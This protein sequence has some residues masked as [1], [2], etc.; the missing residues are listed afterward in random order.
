MCL[1]L[2]H[3]EVDFYAIVSDSGEEKSFRG[4][5][6]ALQPCG[7]AFGRWDVPP[8]NI[9]GPAPKVEIV[10]MYDIL[11]EFFRGDNVTRESTSY[12]LDTYGKFAYQSIKKLASAMHFEYDHALWLDSEAIAVRPFRLRQTFDTHIKAPAVF[13]SRMRNTDF[14]GEIMN[15][16]A[17]VL[18]RSIDSFGPLLWTLESVQWIIERDVLRDMVRYVE[19]AHGRDFWSVWTE[20]HGPFEI[21]LYNLHIVARKLETVSS[22]FSKYAVLETEREMIRFG[23]APAFPEMEFQKGTGFLERGYNLLRRPEIQPNFSAFLRRYG[24]R[25]FR[26]DDLTVAPPE[27][28]TRFILD[29]PLDLLVCGAPPLH[30]WWRHGQDASPPGVV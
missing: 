1:C 12:I 15:N 8:S 26:L 29:T 18:G 28:V 5:L 27:T 4:I 22:V 20:N 3:A 17:K 9:N 16:S 30:G 7:Q 6:D 11:P 21:N 25:L 10:N 13:R 24:Q 23:I 14:M 2:D 19:A